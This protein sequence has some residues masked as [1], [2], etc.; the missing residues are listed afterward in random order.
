MKYTNVVKHLNNVKG[1]V[2]YSAPDA[3]GTQ[4]LSNYFTWKHQQIKTLNESATKSSFKINKI[5][6]P[7]N[8][9]PFNIFLKC[10]S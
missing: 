4:F 6:Q 9:T 7:T 10:R 1:V 8:G 5:F 3:G 2:F